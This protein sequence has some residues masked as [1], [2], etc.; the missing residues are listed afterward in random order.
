VDRF[1][2]DRS[3]ITDTAR[4]FVEEIFSGAPDAAGRSIWCEKTPYNLLSMPFLWELFPEAAIVHIKRDPRGVANS[5]ARQWWAPD[6]IGDV[7]TWLDSVYRRWLG[8][9][10]TIDLAGR[11]FLEVRVED[12]G[13]DP[14]TRTRLIEAMGYGDMSTG[15]LQR[16]INSERSSVSASPSD[17]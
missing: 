10:S 15:R 2:E 3:E 16:L 14:E 1:F 13:A 17:E 8:I 5:M 9:R 6:N 11:C 12:L 4:G 7:I